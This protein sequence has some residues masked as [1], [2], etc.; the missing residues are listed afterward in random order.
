MSFWHESIAIHGTAPDSFLHSTIVPIPKGKNGNVS[1]SA[2]FQGITLSSIYGKLFD[3]IVLSRY[4]D[5][6]SSSELQFGF[7]AKSS[8]NLC[9]M[10]LKESLAYYINNQSSVFC[11]FLDATKAFDRV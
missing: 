9:S 5:H 6:L 10:V 3:N 2:N 11:T 8:N 7:K 4:A 1:D